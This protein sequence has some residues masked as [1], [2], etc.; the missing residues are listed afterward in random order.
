MEEEVWRRRRRCGGG[1]AGVEGEDEEVP[2]CLWC[3]V[4]YQRTDC[5]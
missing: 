4:S 5:V 3:T 2:L 1:G